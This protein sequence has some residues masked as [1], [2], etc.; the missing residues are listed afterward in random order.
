MTIT[1][2]EIKFANSNIQNGPGTGPELETGTVGTG[3]PE[4]ER[5]TGTVGL[6]RWLASKKP[7]NPEKSK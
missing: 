2:L 4:T 3:F 5:G 7:Q 6:V 1:T